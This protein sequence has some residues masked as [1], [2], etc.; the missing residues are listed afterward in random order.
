MIRRGRLC[1]YILWEAGRTPGV[2][3]GGP[4][5]LG[6]PR[7]LRGEI[8]SWLEGR[9]RQGDDFKGKE[10]DSSIKSQRQG[11]PFHGN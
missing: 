4:A 11:R 5:I 9:A 3:P 6:P 7:F 2:H 10:P 8:E 1:I